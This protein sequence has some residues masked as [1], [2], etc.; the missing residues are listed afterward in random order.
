RSPALRDFLNGYDAAGGTK[1]RERTRATKL[2]IKVDKQS[3]RRRFSGT[4]VIAIGN[5]CPT[6]LKKFIRTNRFDFAT[7]RKKANRP[8]L[9]REKHHQLA[10]CCGILLRPFEPLINLHFRR[11]STFL[12]F[13]HLREGLVAR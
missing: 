5:H 13:R 9:I 11:A 4:L 8:I 2:S 6:A 3:R 12:V 1:T 7:P 10:Y